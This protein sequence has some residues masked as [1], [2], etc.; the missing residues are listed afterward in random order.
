MFHRE[1]LNYGF[2]ST[3][4]KITARV[5][6]YIWDDLE[7]W[8]KQGM[9]LITNVEPATPHRQWF[10]DDAEKTEKE[11]LKKP[12][13][14]HHARDMRLINLGKQCKEIGVEIPIDPRFID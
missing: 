13:D 9:N 11:R 1:G 10:F 7:N 14:P 5:N 2:I 12:F 3:E 6:F 4:L 8:R